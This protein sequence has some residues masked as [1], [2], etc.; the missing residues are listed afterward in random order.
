LAGYGWFFEI[1]DE[2]GVGMDEDITKKVLQKH[3]SKFFKLSPHYFNA[4][5]EHEKLAAWLAGKLL[6]E[7]WIKIAPEN[8]KLTM[9]PLYVDSKFL[10]GKAEV[11]NADNVL[12]KGSRVVI[13]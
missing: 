2:I 6:E 10:G 4:D 9:H 13:L 3:I 12:A 5:V 8:L 1:A 11:E 7:G